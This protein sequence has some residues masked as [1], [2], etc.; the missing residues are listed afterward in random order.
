[1]EGEKGSGSVLLDPVR[2]E[3]V[4]RMVTS[5]GMSEFP[6]QDVRVVMNFL[7]IKLRECLTDPILV[8]CPVLV[9]VSLNY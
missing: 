2:L 8:A 3:S 5:A 6:G 9:R 4:M 1:M 7:L